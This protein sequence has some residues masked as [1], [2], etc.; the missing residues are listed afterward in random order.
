MFCLIQVAA[1]GGGEN[2][3][4]VIRSFAQFRSRLDRKVARRRTP[5]CKCNLAPS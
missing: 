4:P 5:I 2:N 1:Q 3:Q